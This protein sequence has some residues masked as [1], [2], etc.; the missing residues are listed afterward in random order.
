MDDDRNPEFLALDQVVEEAR[1]E[2]EPDIDWQRVEAS[3]MDKLDQE[4]TTPA[5]GAERRFGWPAVAA[6]AAAAAVGIFSVRALQSPTSTPSATETEVR[7]AEARTFRTAEVN[8]AALSVGDRVVAEGHSVVV[9]HSGRANW[10]LASGSQAK[11]VRSG[12]FL[13]VQLVSGSV[14]A[15]VVPDKRAETFAVEVA[16]TR[17]A[18]H[19]T[20]FT[21]KRLAKKSEVTVEEG[22]VAVGPKS[23]PGQTQGF[24]LRAGDRGAFALDGRSGN[25][26]RAAVAQLPEEAESEQAAPLKTPKA[27]AAPLPTALPVN[28]M[29]KALDQ[30]QSSVMHCFN[31][32][33]SA[34]AGV[35]ITARTR[36]SLSFAGSGRVNT[37]RFEPPLAPAVQQCAEGAARG[38]KVMRT[39]NGGSASRMVL[40][41]P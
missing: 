27:A 40:V 13:T 23:A 28:A 18:V 5:A 16:D 22:V 25:V 10:T 9:K 39:Q 15:E 3:L 35:R 8:G 4:P 38:L 1:G 11:L 31:K 29:E 34:E 19:G 14:R 37:V 7:S 33:T 24:T 36:A 32:H 2:P 12:R 41:G 21:V 6:L 17:V 20:V 30:L 26:T